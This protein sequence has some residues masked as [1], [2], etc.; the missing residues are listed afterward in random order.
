MKISAIIFDLDNTVFPVSSIGE[1]LFEPIFALIANSKEYKGDLNAI[2]KDI[3]R[4][5]FQKVAAEYQ[6]SEKLLTDGINLLK[7]LSYHKPIRPFEDYEA[8]RNLRCKKFLVTT[9]FVKMQE[10][11]I[12][13]LGIEQ[14]FER[15]Y[16]V[17]PTLVNQTKKDIFKHILENH[18]LNASDVLV[19]GDDPN[20]EIQAA[21][22]LGI[23]TVL[24][25][26]MNF[27]PEIKNVTR[28]ADYADLLKMIDITQK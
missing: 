2:K 22:E 12:K 26:K 1:E 9:G 20:S 13:Q 14:D 19:V 27:N 21:N 5:P 6:F 7:S 10:S 23:S 3:M 25:D 28:I 15:I 4:K 11:K 16:I 8:T 18:A 17:D 24:Y